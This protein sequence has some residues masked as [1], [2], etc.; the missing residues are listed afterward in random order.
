MPVRELMRAGRGGAGGGGG[1]G[2]RQR[3]L[4]IQQPTAEA[5][6]MRKALKRPVGSLELTHLGPG[7]TEIY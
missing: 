1:G 5:G 6:G 3:M 7:N 2:D 4:E